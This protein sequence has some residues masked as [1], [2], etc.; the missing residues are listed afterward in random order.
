MLQYQSA[1]EHLQRSNLGI[2]SKGLYFVIQKFVACCS[3][4]FSQVYNSQDICFIDDLC[5]QLGDPEGYES[6]N[7]DLG[8]VDTSAVVYKKSTIT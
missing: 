5:E 1:S 3:I 8:R 4:D 2:W 7:F 6:K